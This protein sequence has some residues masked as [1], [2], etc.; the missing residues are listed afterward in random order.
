VRAGRVTGE[1]KNRE[2]SWV[3]KV[4]G[5]RSRGGGAKTGST[6]LQGGGGGRGGGGTARGKRG[7]TSWEYEKK[8]TA[9][10]LTRLK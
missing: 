9:T 3:R 2:G 10:N 1:H 8:N 6:E 7:R 5:V 4:R